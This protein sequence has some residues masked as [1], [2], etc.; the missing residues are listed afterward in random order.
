MVCMIGITFILVMKKLFNWMVG[1]GD[2]V[3]GMMYGIYLLSY[4]EEDAIRQ[5]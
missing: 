2:L 5:K 4:L 1:L 3:Y